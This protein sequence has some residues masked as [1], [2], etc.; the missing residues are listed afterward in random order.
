LD[1]STP[2]KPRRLAILAVL[3]GATCLVGL[4]GLLLT[5]RQTALRVSMSPRGFQTNAAGQLCALVVVTNRSTRPYGIAF[6]TQSKS[7]GWTNASLV[8]LAAFYAGNGDIRVKPRSEREFLVPLRGVGAPWRLV[9]V[10][11]EQIPPRTLRYWLLCRIRGSWPGY[12]KF[13]TS[14]E[15][16]SNPAAPGNGATSL[17]FHIELRGRA[18]PEPQCWGA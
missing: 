10:Y 16:S 13:L 8:P 18:V 14:P 15:I 5:G 7:G 6:A 2:M 4:A 12:R 17:L 1:D 11:F 9:A 3:A